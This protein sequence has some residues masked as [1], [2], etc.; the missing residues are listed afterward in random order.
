MYISYGHSVWLASIKHHNQIKQTYTR[1]FHT[2]FLYI[3]SY[4]VWTETVIS[5][6]NFTCPE[7]MSTVMSFSVQI[8]KCKFAADIKLFFKMTSSYKP[9]TSKLNYF[10]THVHALKV[11][12]ISHQY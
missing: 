4:H 11:K 7:S 10:L 2:A 1:I 9:Q 6:S 8:V 12:F 5:H 3:W